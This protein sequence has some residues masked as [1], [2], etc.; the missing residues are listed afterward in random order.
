MALRRF[1]LKPMAELV[2]DL[3]HSVTHLLTAEMLKAV[4]D[5]GAPVGE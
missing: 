3:P 5:Q 4:R 2:P 1:V